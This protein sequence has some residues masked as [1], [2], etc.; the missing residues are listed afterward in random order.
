M[1]LGFKD[2]KFKIMKTRAV[3]MILV[4]LSLAGLSACPLQQVFKKKPAEEAP[5]QPRTS[6]AELEQEIQQLSAENEALKD[7]VTELE[8]RLTLASKQRVG[9]EDLLEQM[10]S[11]LLAAVDEATQAKS[12]LE[13]PGS[14]ASAITTLAEARI[15]VDK[16]RH[17][18][19]A[20]RVKGHLDSADRMIA[21]ASRQI[22]AGNFNGAIYFARSAQRTV[23]GALKLAQLDAEQGGR[24]LV[25]ALAQANLRQGPSQDSDKIARLAQGTKVL[26]LEKRGDWIRVYVSDTGATGWLHTSVVK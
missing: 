7:K 26:Q 23:E 3:L 4:V 9:Q 11:D 12:A 22:E 25:V 21:A 16:A 24:V 15:A 10:R 13:K 20:D 6:R 8:R 19:L 2:V 14:Q 1:R 17:H 5:A 18:P